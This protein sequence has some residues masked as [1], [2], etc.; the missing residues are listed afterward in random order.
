MG[1]ERSGRK[2]V[3][4]NLRILRGNPTGKPI[5]Q[6]EPKPKIPSSCP[7]PPLI[8]KGNKQ[9]RKEWNRVAP[10]LYELGLLSEL[11]VPMLANYCQLWSRLME[12]ND[13]INELQNNPIKDEESGIVHADHLIVTSPKG[14]AQQNALIGIYNTTAKEMR[15]IMIEFGMSPSAR[16]RMNIKPIEKESALEKLRKRR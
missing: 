9:A 2:P 4:T 1:K 16:S 14:Y 6:N 5:N 15:A 3:P 12:V 13:R 10:Q 11:E 8:L 7:K